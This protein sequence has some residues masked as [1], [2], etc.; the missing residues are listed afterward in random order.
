MASTPLTGIPPTQPGCGDVS[1]HNPTPRCF[2]NENGASYNELGCFLQMTGLLCAPLATTRGFLFTDDPFSHHLVPLVPQL[3]TVTNRSATNPPSNLVGIDNQPVKYQGPARLGQSCV[4]IPLPSTTDPL[5]RTLANIANQRLNETV[6]S[7]PGVGA[8]L[9]VFNLRGDC[10]RG[11]YC[12]LATPG[13]GVGTC[14]EQLPNYHACSSYMQCISLRCDESL[15]PTELLSRR[16]A[17]STGSFLNLYQSRIHIMEKRAKPTICLPSKI[18]DDNG[19]NELG[20]GSGTRGDDQTNGD[21]SESAEADDP[22]FAPWMGAVIAMAIILG[23]AVIFGLVR[24]RKTLRERNEKRIKATDQ[25]INMRV[26][27]SASTYQTIRP[28][29]G[30]HLATDTSDVSTDLET[31]SKDTKNN[32]D[33][34]HHM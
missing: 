7:S 24:R 27:S 8:G 12:D 18:T 34:H 31:F 21:D 14:K 28:G 10:Q 25:E 19:L 6:G 9:D 5:F 11:S 2:N 26:V 1:I 30:S 29:T 13:S 15:A 3:S 23:A 16:K 17:R 22:K 32:K 20:V 4:G 33:H